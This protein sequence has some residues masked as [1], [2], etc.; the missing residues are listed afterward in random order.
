MLCVS[1]PWCES[2]PDEIQDSG[3]EYAESASILASAISA[4]KRGNKACKFPYAVSR[5]NSASQTSL[6]QMQ[7][8]QQ[9]NTA[10]TWWKFRAA[11]TCLTAQD[12]LSEA[13]QE[14]LE[15]C[16]Q[17]ASS[18]S[19]E[20]LKSWTASWQVTTASH[21][22]LFE[23]SQ[24]AHKVWLG[25]MN[26]ANLPN[27]SK[28]YTAARAASWTCTMAKAWKPSDFCRSPG[29]RSVQNHACKIRKG[30]AKLTWG[31]SSA[32]AVSSIIG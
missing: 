23:F 8:M 26:K 12:E 16:K 15:G 21:Q 17:S 7:W 19:F 25:S 22:A 32:E 28:R 6:D 10:L 1:S 2:C 27:R 5:S 24:F 30:W 14:I 11:N 9:P 20:L 3:Q 29:R 4:Q 31:H 18:Q 13:A